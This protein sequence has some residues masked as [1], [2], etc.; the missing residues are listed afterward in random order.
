MARFSSFSFLFLVI[1]FLSACGG[2][3]GDTPPAPITPPAPTIY[4]VNGLAVKGPISNASVNLYRIDL[5]QSN[6]KGELVDSG[7][8]GETARFIDLEAEDLGDAFYLLEVGSK[9]DTIDLNTGEAP[10]FDLMRSVISKAQLTGQTTINV[11]PLTTLVTD[12]TLNN[13]VSLAGMQTEI[14]K[15]EAFVKEVFGFGLLDGI[16]IFTGELLLSQNTEVMQEMV[17]HRMAVEAL[18]SLI[19]EIAYYT[20][21]PAHLLLSLFSEDLQ[22]GLLDAKLYEEAMEPFISQDDG[23]TQ[24][25][26]YSEIVDLAFSSHINSLPLVASEN[27]KDSLNSSVYFSVAQTPE[28]IAFEQVALDT[29]LDTSNLTNGT[30][31]VRAEA[32]GEDFDNDGI[33]DVSDYDDDNDGALDSVDAF[34]FDPTET[35][36]SDN[37]GIGDNSDAYPEDKGCFVQDQGNGQMCYTSY[38]ESDGNRLISTIHLGGMR[39]GFNVDTNGDSLIDELLIQN[40]ETQSFES[41][42][43]ELNAQ[44]ILYIAEQNRIYFAQEQ[45]VKYLNLLNEQ[46]GFAQATG[47][48]RDLININGRILVIHEGGYRGIAT[49]YDLNGLPTAQQELRYFSTVRTWSA[50]NSRIYHFRDCCTPRDILYLE[51]DPESNTFGRQQDSP[52]HGSYTIS[53]PILVAPNGNY[54]LTGAGDLY[55]GETLLWSASIGGS[56]SFGYWPKNEEVVIL[57]DAGNESLLRRMTLSGNVLEHI[58]IDGNS[59]A[60]HPV[61]DSAIVV[62]RTSK[63]LETSLYIPKGDSDG[64]GIENTV[65]QFPLDIAASVDSDRDG[66]PDGWNE[67]FSSADSTTQ[68]VLD[69]FPN[70]S[71]CWLNSHELNGECDY[72]ATMP[73]FTPDQI[74]YDSAGNIYLASFDGGKLYVWSPSQNKYNNPINISVSL[75]LSESDPTEIAYSE[76]HNRIYIGYQNGSI[77]Y[78]DLENPTEIVSFNNVSMSVGGV[79]AV[80]DYVLIQDSS[81]A[82]NTHYI[83][84]Q[85]GTLTDQEDWNRRSQTYA[86][87]ETNSRVY[88]LRDGISPRDLHYETINQS[89]GLITAGGETPYHSSSG[90][91]HPVRVSENGQFVILGSGR[92]FNADSLTEVTN[93]QRESVDTLSL[94]GVLMFAEQ[95]GLSLFEEGDFSYLESISQAGSPLRLVPYQGDVISVRVVDDEFTFDFIEIADSDNDGLPGWWEN[96]NDLDDTNSSDAAT[97]AD[98]DQLTALEEFSVGTNP[99]ISDTDED[100]LLDSEEVNT[101]PLVADTDSD[102]LVD[103]EEVNIYLTDPVLADTDEDG[104]NDGDEINSYQTNPLLTDTDSDGL[105]DLWEVNNALQ[106]TVDD[107]QGDIDSDELVNIDEFIHGTD[108][109]DSDTDKD[110]LNDGVE[111]HTYASLPLV[112]D[113]D[114]DRM[115]DDFEVYN[116]FNLLDGSDAANDDDNDGYTNMEEYFLGSDPR[117]ASNIPEIKEW[118]RYQG[119]SGH[120]GFLPIEIDPTLLQVR[121][122]SYYNTNGSQVVSIEDDIYL[123]DQNMGVV[124]VNIGNGAADWNYSSLESTGLIT[125]LVF[126]DKIWVK[127]QSNLRSIERE[128]GILSYVVSSEGFNYSSAALNRINDF[129]IVTGNTS[130]NSFDDNGEHVWQFGLGGTSYISPIVNN[131][132]TNASGQFY[133]LNGENGEA[134]LETDVFDLLSTNLASSM[135]GSYGNLIVK[136]RDFL[137]SLDTVNGQILWQKEIES[138]NREVMANAYGRVFVADRSLQVFDELTGDLLWSWETPNN[139]SISN[140]IVVARNLVFV[141]SHSTTYALSLSTKQMVWSIDI[142]GKLSLQK[143]GTLFIAGNSEVVAVDLGFDEDGDSLPNYWEIQYNLDYL[144]ASNQLSDP[145]SDNLNNLAEFTQSTNPVND[146]SDEDGLNDG[147]EVNSQGT[148]PLESDSDSDGILDGEELNTYFTDPLDSDS[149]D[150]GYSDGAEVHQ[151][152]SDP[153]DAD[154]LPSEITSIDDQFSGIEFPVGWDTP[155]SSELFPWYLEG[156][157]MRSADI[158]DSQFSEIEYSGVLATGKLSFEFKVDSE[159][160]CDFLYIYLD[161]EQVLR[162]STSDWEPLELD[163]SNGEHT[164][165]FRYAKDGSVSEGEDATFI[166][167]FIF[168]A[169]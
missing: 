86:W 56:F 21:Q 91:R 8:T 61:G 98:N 6:Y 169:D 149:D 22:D 156:N 148:N 132:L 60:I 50:E 18:S 13:T 151:Y 126:G 116:N 35:T 122:R 83:F 152:G 103:G 93:L 59:V 84:A 94:G 121:W 117:S 155:Q 158:G 102:G 27:L 134:L 64:D 68:L 85:D 142:G 4:S 51:V 99:N 15:T 53:G 82:W 108:P 49:L 52:H 107:A 147:E 44:A 38:I 36:D 54:V 96:A 160:C 23:T 66:Y 146:D 72:S 79:A 97:D 109:R 128:E 118:S 12:I 62:T 111:V 31:V 145:D 162:S 48:I 70:D 166:R 1:T 75:G 95:N 28:L 129:T 127:T 120:T 105:D 135:S 45:E 17:E 150:D 159:S 139:R 58:V 167:S 7:S 14:T 137:L 30:V 101:D 113:T 143:L 73:E 16:D 136:S 20:S 168:T 164:I 133:V 10:L 165:R 32:I 34:P 123:L 57:S 100:G 77:R 87:N 74:E 81:G 71:A 5:S 114:G 19:F 80:G 125:P 24:I 26:Y 131:S 2:G 90:I 43:R 153:N 141:S 106:P 89:S 163:I 112:S 115:R 157:L 110:G 55:D 138:Q 29:G 37:D 25:V 144:D 124:S 88:F 11:T 3:G 47:A 65:D 69:V 140:N 67:G 130:I 76:S 42:H 46:V 41:M 33:P 119:N 161:E 63:G 78:V 40:V 39:V 104:L 154:S 9:E 92:I